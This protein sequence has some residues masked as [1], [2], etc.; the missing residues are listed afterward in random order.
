MRGTASTGFENRID[1][2]LKSFNVAAGL[3]PGAARRLCTGRNFDRL[4]QSLA[5]VGTRRQPD[6]G[7]KYETAKTVIA[8]TAF[9]APACGEL[10]G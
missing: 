10:P 1:D 2:P 7:S 9:T 4:N 8:S 5:P 3:G 6:T